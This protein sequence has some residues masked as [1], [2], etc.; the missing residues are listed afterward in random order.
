MSLTVAKCLTFHLLSASHSQAKTRIFV[1]RLNSTLLDTPSAAGPARLLCSTHITGSFGFYT[2]FFTSSSNLC[3]LSRAQLDIGSLKG[4]EGRA[5]SSL[6]DLRQRRSFSSTSIPE[7]ES[8][9]ASELT[10]K[11]LGAASPFGAMMKAPAADD[12][13]LVASP[14]CALRSCF[15]C[16]CKVVT[17]SDG[18]L[19]FIGRYAET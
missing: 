11:D 5:S 8:S 10:T 13:D 7:S 6:R 19:F 2:I 3:T 1:L 16:S 15:L 9:D 12:V 14:P 18:R 17:S 4:L